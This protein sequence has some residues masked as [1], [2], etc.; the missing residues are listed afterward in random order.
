MGDIKW[1]CSLYLPRYKGRLLSLVSVKDTD[2]VRFISAPIPD[3][4][5]WWGGGRGVAL[6]VKG[7]GGEAGGMWGR[8]VGRTS[9]GKGVRMMAGKK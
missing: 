5:R 6:R 1:L 4:G 3:R 7:I 8:V 9:V 2:M